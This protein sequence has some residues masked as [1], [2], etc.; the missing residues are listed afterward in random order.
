MPIS[1][2]NIEINQTPSG[3]PSEQDRLQA[4]VQNAIRADTIKGAVNVIARHLKYGRFELPNTAASN[5]MIAEGLAKYFPTCELSLFT[6][7]IR[8]TVD[9]ITGDKLDMALGTAVSHRIFEPTLSRVVE[10][11]SADYPHIPIPDLTAAAH[12]VLAQECVLA[13]IQLDQ[14]VPLDS[15]EGKE[16][17]LAYIPGL[18]KSAEMEG[19]MTD[20]WSEANYSTSL[21]IKPDAVFRTFLTLANIGSSEWI[22]AVETVHGIRLDEEPDEFA[23]DWERERYAAWCD[24]FVEAE[25]DA[26]PIAGSETLILAV[27]ACAF[28]FTPMVAFKMPASAVVGSAWDQP[29]TV[30]GGVFGL[31]DFK[32]GHGDPIRFEGKIAIEPKPFE[33]QV[34]T[35]MENDLMSVHGFT[36]KSFDSIVEEA[37]PVACPRF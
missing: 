15:L 27:D 5:T 32:N 34:A 17:I 14:T 3:S 4:C 1:K 16:A 23:D 29:L 2:D 33:I 9:T 26:E 10:T 36:A 37:T 24:F 22:D 28:G 30:Q 20:F 13:A 6:Q 35:L 12:K 19:T 31:H 8:D 21:S 11:I 7:H 18:E 25:S